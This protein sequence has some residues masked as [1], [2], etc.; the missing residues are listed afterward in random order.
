VT[1]K[2]RERKRKRSEE[3]EEEEKRGRSEEKKKEK[4]TSEESNRL[5]AL[6]CSSFVILTTHSRYHAATYF[7]SIVSLALRIGARAAM[8]LL[9]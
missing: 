1:A 7:I 9:K 6:A 4:C 8:L 3:E 5:D 2:I